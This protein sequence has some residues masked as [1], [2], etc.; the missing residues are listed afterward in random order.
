MTE[1]EHNRNL[2]ID[3][4]R[5][6]SM[7]MIVLLHVLGQGGILS[8]ASPLSIHWMVA[9]F[10]EILSYVSVNCYAL[11]SG[12]VGFDK[13]FRLSKVMKLWMEVAF[14]TITIML[15]FSLLYPN[16]INRSVINSALMPITSR[17]YWYISAYFG[18]IFL[19]PIVNKAVKNMS[20]IELRKLLIYFSIFGILLPALNLSDP[21]TFQGGY[22]AFWL[23][24]LYLFGA[25][26]KHYSIAQKF[27]FTSLN[28]FFCV[29]TVTSFLLWCL[30]QYLLRFRPGLLRYSMLLVN[31]TAPI[32]FASSLVLFLEFVKF[33]HFS[34]MVKKL[35]KLFAPATLGVYLI[36]VN[37]L[38]WEKYIK[39]FAVGFVNGSATMMAVKVVFTALCIYLACSFVDLLR[40][41][42]FKA[43]RINEICEQIS[44]QIE[45]KLDG[46]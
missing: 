34:F 36:H 19:T 8:K 40:I 26:I 28:S 10:I 17:S 41:Y 18:I 35:I 5:I 2:G 25:Y 31:Y 29:T 23:L 14:Y 27:S 20:E 44:N 38:I 30:L 15:V 3:L 45:E 1:K 7:F 22:T 37:H 4:L 42:L 13:G 33:N 21:M 46:Q 24:Y 11:I 9:W 6:V 16:M 39:G 43:L 12:Y 32:M